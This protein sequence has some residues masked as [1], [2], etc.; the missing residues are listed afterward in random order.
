MK[1]NYLLIL[2]SVTYFFL[3]CGNDEK[4]QP[5]KAIQSVNKLTPAPIKKNP[6]ISSKSITA[7]RKIESQKNT[8][9]NTFAV[10]NKIELKTAPPESLNKTEKPVDIK[11]EANDKLVNFVNLRKIFD[12]CKMGQ[13]LSQKQLTE[14]FE[15]PKEAVKLV[16]S[17]TRTAENELAV[18]WQ[19]TWFV[20]K[21]SDAELEDGKMKVVFK[22]NKMYTSGNAIGIKYNRKVYN[23]LVIIGRSAYIPSVKGYSW[24][25]GR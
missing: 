9:Q 8:S 19:S 1:K 5:K 3:S 6:K 12:K 21:V 2:F 4:K 13:T 23:N 15:I 7:S 17:V 20:E 24:Q 10:K 25:I 14:N 16:K 11:K 22:A 18:K